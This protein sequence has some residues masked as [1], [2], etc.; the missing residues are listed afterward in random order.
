MGDAV[1]LRGRDQADAT[2]RRTRE[3]SHDSIP[4]GIALEI[5]GG[6]IHA[7]EPVE[8]IQHDKVLEGPVA[9]AAVH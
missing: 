5:V 3:Q 7:V 8:A 6:R 4:D 9:I 1:F 2:Y